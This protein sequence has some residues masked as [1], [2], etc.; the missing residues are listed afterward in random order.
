MKYQTLVLCL[1]LVSSSHA[2][3]ILHGSP[4]A[5]TPKPYT[6]PSK[7]NLFKTAPGASDKV[8]SL[9]G[10]PDAEFAS[11]P[12]QYAGILP[13]TGV[14][15]LFYW[16]FE[17]QG[18]PTDPLLIWLNGGPGCSSM[19][20]LFEELGPLKVDANLQVS[21][22]PYTW[23]KHANMLF[24]DQPAG[25]GLSYVNNDDESLLATTEA[26]VDA[27]FYEFLN[28]FFE[29][30]PEL[31][32]LDL[33]IIG[34]SYGGQYVPSIGALIVKRNQRVSVDQRIN[35]K[36][37]GVGNGW[38]DP[39]I[40]HGAYIDYA[41]NIGIIS[42]EVKESLDTL[43]SDCKDK[44]EADSNACGGILDTILSG[45][46]S[47]D[48]ATINYYDIRDYRTDGGKDYPIPL[49]YGRY[50][51]QPSVREAVHATEVPHE[52]VQC[53]DPAGGALS[54]EH[55]RSTLNLLP[56]LLDN[57]V[58]VVF[59]NGQFDLICNHVGNDRFLEAMQW[60]GQAEYVQSPAIPWIVNKIPAGYVKSHGLLSFITVLGG[61]H[62][63][64]YDRPFQMQEFARLFV[65]GAP[66]VDSSLQ[67]SL[68]STH[69]HINVSPHPSDSST[70]SAS[71]SLLVPVCVMSALALVAALAIFTVKK[72]NSKRQTSPDFYPPAQLA[73]DSSYHKLLDTHA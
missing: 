44:L 58:R 18:S 4:Q 24:V 42:N 31:R 3:M 17:S 73:S 56:I 53:S 22:N 62:M 9:P 36:G 26:E 7:L 1:V 69:S 54:G 61:G 34:E 25:T 16:F 50:M 63:T 51:N 29:V 60:S 15:H 68:K 5:T 52:W 46:G 6:H 32:K 64:P 23:N 72:R 71:S 10:M 37:I 28:A 13:K 59:Y 41:Y 66:F 40:Q 43:Y 21:M 38:T 48:S 30:H 33:Y 27:R 11:L 2:R 14:H 39:Y 8:L 49:D 19:E 47:G 20:G 12:T 67:V 65:S 45:S 35:L 70:G 55:A 57:D